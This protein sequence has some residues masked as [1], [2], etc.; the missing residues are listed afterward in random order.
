M[1]CFEV[2]NHFCFTKRYRMK[3][4]LFPTCVF[5]NRSIF[6]DHFPTT[7]L[8][9][10]TFFYEALPKS[11]VTGEIDFFTKSPYCGV[12]QSARKFQ[13]L[14]RGREPPGEILQNFF[15][16]WQTR[17]TPAK[18]FLLCT[19]KNE[20]DIDPRTPH[21]SFLLSTLKNECVIDPRTPREMFL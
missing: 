3:M 11:T 12:F 17:E 13:F 2:L 15:N 20:C 19:L 6:L 8:H 18:V 9:Q 16:L 14:T 1:H 7:T 10:A 21:E 4:L 5:L